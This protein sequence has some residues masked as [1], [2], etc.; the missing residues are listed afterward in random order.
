MDDGVLT[1]QEPRSSLIRV[2][3]R[4]QKQSRGQGEWGNIVEVVY[5]NS[6]GIYRQQSVARSIKSHTS[7]FFCTIF[8]YI[9]DAVANLSPSNPAQTPMC[10]VQCSNLSLGRHSDVRLRRDRVF[11]APKAGDGL[12]LRVEHDTWLSV[13][14]VC[15]TTRDRLLVTGEGEH[16][17]NP[18]GFLT[19]KPD[20]GGS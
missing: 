2:W 1:S 20:K 18:S 12:L 15:T 13:E 10:I 7:C 14:R 6:N 17:F 19:F 4:V 5:M 3:G 11:A 9:R 16:Y 8:S